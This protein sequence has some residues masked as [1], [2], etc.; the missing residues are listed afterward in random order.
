[1]IYANLSILDYSVLYVAG[2]LLNNFASFKPPYTM[3]DTPPEEEIGTTLSSTER[4]KYMTIDSGDYLE[5][6]RTEKR[7]L[8]TQEEDVKLMSS[9]LHNSTDS[10]IGADRKNE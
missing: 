10:S 6:S 3:E 1:M 7:I 4:N 8:W 2:G 9:W 5:L